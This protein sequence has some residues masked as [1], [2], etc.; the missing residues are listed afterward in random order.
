MLIHSDYAQERLSLADCSTGVLLWQPQI[1]I[2]HKTRF[3]EEVGFAVMVNVSTIPVL[4]LNRWIT[5]IDWGKIEM[6]V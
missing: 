6:V 2:G 4:D 5:I 3:L 1:W